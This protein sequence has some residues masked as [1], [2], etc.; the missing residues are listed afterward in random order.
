MAKV[1]AVIQEKG[2]TGKSTIATNLAGMMV[3]RKARRH[4]QLLVFL[5]VSL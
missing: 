4:K 2:G 3:S 5:L 1:I